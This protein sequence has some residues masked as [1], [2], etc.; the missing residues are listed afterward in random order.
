MHRQLEGNEVRPTHWRLNAD[1]RIFAGAGGA[2][3]SSLGAPLS[4][5]VVQR[6]LK[7]GVPLAA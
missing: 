2:R 3:W 4:E 7:S 5:G 1:Q 6:R